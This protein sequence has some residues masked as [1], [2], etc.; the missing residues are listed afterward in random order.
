[1]H[2]VGK[3]FGDLAAFRRDDLDETKV[4]E[5]LAQ[6]GLEVDQFSDGYTSAPEQQS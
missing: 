6:N 5:L 3:F 4:G 2:H 1:V